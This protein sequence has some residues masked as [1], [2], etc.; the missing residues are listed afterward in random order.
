[1]FVFSKTCALR[2][3]LMTSPSFL[4][5]PFVI[6]AMVQRP[7]HLT[8]S[9]RHRLCALHILFVF[10]AMRATFLPRTFAFPKTMLSTLKTA[11]N[12]CL[13]FRLS[14]RRTS[15]RK[16][17]KALFVRLNA[18][19]LSGLLRT[20]WRL[21]LKLWKASRRTLRHYSLLTPAATRKPTLKAKTCL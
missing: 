8:T 9:W 1:M 12:S 7:V 20:N 16:I 11:I 17:A 18:A 5:N 19:R 21:T 3:S 6:K 15:T 10:I 14:C 4:T 13:K 2:R